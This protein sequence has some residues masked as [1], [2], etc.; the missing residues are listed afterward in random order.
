[1]T[2]FEIFE[3]VLDVMD[4]IDLSYLEVSMTEI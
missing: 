2:Q 4:D 3:W 1:M